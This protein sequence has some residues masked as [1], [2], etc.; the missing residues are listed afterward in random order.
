MARKST[1]TKDQVS[2]IRE[3]HHTKATIAEICEA[4]GITKGKVETALHKIKYQD[5]AEAE[6]ATAA[7]IQAL[8]TLV[9]QKGARSIFDTAAVLD[10]CYKRLVELDQTYVKAVL[11]DRVSVQTEIRQLSSQA[12][13]T[14]QYVFELLLKQFLQEVTA[15]IDAQVPGTRE[16]IYT[17]LAQ[18]GLDSL[19]KQLLDI[20]STG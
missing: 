15:I 3:L 13:T 16:I 11:R 14:K 7:E 20:S 17:Q 18:A 12:V 4:T 9:S 8:T 5:A 1:L 10:D 2:Q 19:A 6:L